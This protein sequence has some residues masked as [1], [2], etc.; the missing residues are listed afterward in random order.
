[1]QIKVHQKDVAGKRVQVC[2]M[3]LMAMV[4][5][6]NSVVIMGWMAAAK[7][8]SNDVI[9]DQPI[10]ISLWSKMKWT[11]HCTKD[12]RLH[13]LLSSVMHFLLQLVKPS[14]ATLIWRILS[15]TRRLTCKKKYKIWILYNLQKRH[16]NYW[17]SC[18]QVINMSF[19]IIYHF[20]TKTK[21]WG[22]FEEATN[23]LEYPCMLECSWGSPFS[24]VECTNFEKAPIGFATLH[25]IANFFP[26]FL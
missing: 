12:F 6:N 11:N 20:E 15:F 25:K 18:E 17:I 9:S 3:T 21:L 7:L 22:Y 23:Q 10:I 13:P 2:K 19:L 14:K 1:M 8:I 5:A 24:Y 16:L 26:A 4:V